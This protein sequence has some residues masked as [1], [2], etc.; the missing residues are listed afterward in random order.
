[1]EDIEDQLIPGI[2]DEDLYDIDT[3]KEFKEAFEMFDADQSGTIDVGELGTVL[4]QLGQNISQAELEEMIK[5]VD[6]DESGEID[7]D[8]FL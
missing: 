6:E 4:T 2:D 8:E 7:F 1:M 5:E 3:I